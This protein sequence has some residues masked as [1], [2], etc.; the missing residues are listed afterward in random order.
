MRK[1][2]VSP[3]SALLLSSYPSLLLGLGGVL[4][5]SQTLLGW[6]SPGG[7][8][9]A[10][11]ATL[12]SI[13][14]LAGL[15]FGVARFSELA[16][17]TL[18]EAENGDERLAAKV[19]VALLA[20]F[21]LLAFLSA[22]KPAHLVQEGDFVNYHL[23]LP[24][25]HWLAGSWRPIEWSHF[26]YRTLLL[27]YAL[28]YLWVGLPLLNKLPQ[29]V[30]VLFLALKLWSF[31]RELGSARPH[32]TGL[33][34]VLALF[35]SRGVAVQVGTAMLDLPVIYFLVSLA[36]GVLCFQKRRASGWLSLVFGI[37]LA[38][39]LG[40]KSFG[41]VF[42]VTFLF[43]SEIMLR[44]L[45]RRSLLGFAR[46]L[47]WRWVA[48]PV[49]ALWGA[50]LARSF[51]F[52]GDPLYPLALPLTRRFCDSSRLLSSRCEW[53]VQ[54]AETIRSD[55]FAYGYGYGLKG[56]LKAFLILPL[57][58]GGQSPVNNVFDYPLGLVWYLGWG[59]L[60]AAAAFSRKLR[61]AALFSG[62]IAVV[63]FGLWFMGS[64]QSRWLYPVLLLFAMTLAYFFQA[65]LAGA[66]GRR[67]AALLASTVAVLGCFVAVNGARVVRSQR[68]TLG[69]LGAECLKARAGYYADYTR[70]C[71]EAPLELDDVAERGYLNCRIYTR[72]APAR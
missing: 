25:Q 7:A 27:D 55:A 9:A 44:L 53:I 72:P 18:A 30:F 13:A 46:N 71:P 3:D 28:S 10:L 61:P 35:A 59:T 33:V 16:R 42:F 29:F 36:L 65:I 1:R 66:R 23:M 11:L 41:I 48:V 14:L 37:D 8:G 60:L 6:W 68:W 21:L 50:N 57:S 12:A 20:G 43:G 62:A 49:V 2:N 4:F 67:R 47:R 69:C 40:H 31:F 24:K 17:A 70:P 32:L 45:F 38:A 22:L 5:Y 26:E 34:A 64:Q 56:L 63:F 39:Y 58:I 15:C 54:M 52:A 19:L 51:Y